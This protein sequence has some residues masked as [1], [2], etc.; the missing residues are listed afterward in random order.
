MQRSRFIRTVSAAAVAPP[1][2]APTPPPAQA[3]PITIGAS[4]S[5][6]GIFADGGKYSLEGYQLWI[7]QQNAKGGV[8]GRQIALKFYDDQSEPATGVRLY[9]R[10]INE[11]K[12]DIIIGP[13]GRASAGQ[14]ETGTV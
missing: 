13:Y 9:E 1:L 2:G 5:L 11:D 7:K 4:L 8:L 12:V 3:G 6:T 14:G 10:L